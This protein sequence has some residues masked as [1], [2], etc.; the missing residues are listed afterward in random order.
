M[1]LLLALALLVA[2]AAAVALVVRRARHSRQ[3]R[4]SRSDPFAPDGWRPDPR[5]LKVGDV[6]ALEGRDYIV[7]GTI[8]MNRAGISWE[9]HL[10]DDTRGRLWLS[11]EDDEGLVLCLWERVAGPTPDPGA[12]TLTYDGVEF[13]LSERG[14][15]TFMAEGTTGTGSSGQM[16]YVDYA[17]GEDRLS[18]ERFASTTWEVSRGRVIGERELTIYPVTR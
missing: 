17:A 9:E 13:R 2:A 4:P 10:L 1:K 16:E 11:V 6:V 5:R 12:P 14:K 7:R 3:P 8:R 18:F 15:A